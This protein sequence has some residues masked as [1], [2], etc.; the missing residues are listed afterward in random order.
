MQSKNQLIHL[1]ILK[2]KN[3][4]I[5]VKREDLLHPYISG[6]KYRKLKYNLEAA[7]MKG[8]HTLLTFGG[9]YS[10]HIDALAYA[11]KEK[12]LQTIG[13]IRGEEIKNTW[14]NNT[15]LKR[16]SANGMEFK[17]VSREVYREKNSDDFV[18]QL[19]KD[20]GDFY[21]I[22]EGG[23][24]ALAVK[25]CE[26]ILSSQ[27][28]KY[29]IICTCVG[30]GG[31]VSGLINASSTSQKVLGFSALKGDFLKSDISKM[32][33]KDNWRLI[34]DYHFGGYAKVNRELIHF[35]NQFKATTAIPLD[36]IYTGKM[37][38]GLLDMVKNDNFEAGTSILVIHTGGI[39]GIE[40]MNT[41]L[42]KKNL[43]L[44]NI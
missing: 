36:P 22:P 44:L 2:E 1:P 23:T 15:T 8:H 18:S 19:R 24:N 4:S 35:I 7:Q 38:F 31:T 32:V 20:F 37:L 5:T 13:V 29:N 6:N 28:K 27:D 34:T 33:K 12:G 26:E 25:G 30:T 42:K 10:N 16:A 41:V 14:E 21:T 17:F 9:A 3:I 39:Q 43:P 40:G 11:G